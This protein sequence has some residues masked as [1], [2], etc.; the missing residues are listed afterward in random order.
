MLIHEKIHTVIS[1]DNVVLL[2]YIPFKNNNACCLVF[3]PMDAV[4]VE[5]LKD[6]VL[7]GLSVLWAFSHPHTPRG[8]VD[9]LLAEQ[10]HCSGWR[11]Y[12]VCS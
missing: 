1:S 2:F 5:F 12:A 7:H 4:K 6:S 10:H 9:L 8:I 3:H 11:L